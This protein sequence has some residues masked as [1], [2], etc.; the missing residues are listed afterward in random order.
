MRPD[1]AIVASRV[2]TRFHARVAGEVWGADE[3]E[4]VRGFLETGSG[5]LEALPRVHARR[6]PAALEVDRLER[7]RLNSRATRGDGLKEARRLL[8]ALNVT[9]VALN[10]TLNEDVR[11]A[12]NFASTT[13]RMMK[14]VARPHVVYGHAWERALAICGDFEE[15]G[16]AAL[17]ADAALHNP[18]IAREVARAVAAGDMGIVEDW[19]A[20]RLGRSRWGGR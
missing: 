20:H 9:I 19:Y 8:E 10:A 4:A 15:H 1:P 14:Q 5:A 12:P 2:A 3:D 18:W 11:R 6:E 17:R 13:L 16:L 7:R